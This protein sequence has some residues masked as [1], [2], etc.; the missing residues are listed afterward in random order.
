MMMRRLAATFL[1]PPARWPGR[2]RMSLASH[3]HIGQSAGGRVLCAFGM[4]PTQSLSG[5]AA[6][7]YCNT[8]VRTTVHR[9]ITVLS[10]AGADSS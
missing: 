7:E 10:R 2:S 9:P 3:S 6:H 4:R 5:I 8:R 1:A